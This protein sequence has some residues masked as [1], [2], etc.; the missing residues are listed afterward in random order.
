MSEPQTT[1]ISQCPGNCLIS[2][3]PIQIRRY[4]CHSYGGALSHLKRADISDK[5]PSQEMSY[6]T[7]VLFNPPKPQKFLAALARQQRG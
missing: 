3:E 6:R 1:P 5:P 2:R 7:H 4:A